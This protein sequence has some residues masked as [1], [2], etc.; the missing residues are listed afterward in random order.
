MLDPDKLLQPAKIANT[1]GRELV[2][3][4]IGPTGYLEL[5]S[6]GKQLRVIPPRKRKYT[7]TDLDQELYSRPLCTT[8]SKIPALLHSSDGAQLLAFDPLQESAKACASCFLILSA[9]PQLETF[10]PDN[11][12]AVTISPTKHT[13]REEVQVETFGI[14]P[15]LFLTGVRLDFPSTEYGTQPSI[16]ETRLALLANHGMS[17]EPSIYSSPGPAKI[18]LRQSSRS[19]W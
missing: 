15:R 12:R 19:K 4:S 18:C 10:V 2:N 16:R 8:C 5:R 1:N 14:Q 6:P 3:V 7:P 13:R 11:T 9:A 17:M